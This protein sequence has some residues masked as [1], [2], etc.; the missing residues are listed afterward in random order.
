MVG[1]RSPWYD[2][3]E[4]FLPEVS[5]PPLRIGP[6]TSASEP[7]YHTDW[8]TAG[9]SYHGEQQPQQQARDDH[10]FPWQSTVGGPTHSSALASIASSVRPTPASPPTIREGGQVRTELEYAA[11]AT[12]ARPSHL[13]S[14]M[15]VSYHPPEAPVS[16]EVETPVTVAPALPP[17]PAAAWRG[18]PAPRLQREPTPP[19]DSV[20]LGD[21]FMSAADLAAVAA[22][23]GEVW[24]TF[25]GVDGSGQDTAG[26]ASFAGSG[27]GTGIGPAASSTASRAG[28][29][30]LSRATASTTSSSGGGGG[31][32][33][34][35]APVTVA[36]KW[37]CTSCP[38]SNAPT[39]TWC[40]ACGTHKSGEGPVRIM[41]RDDAPPLTFSSSAAMPRSQAA[42]PVAPQLAGTNRPA[43]PAPPL[44]HHVAPAP[45]APAGTGRRALKAA[46][47]AAAAVAATDT[48]PSSDKGGG[49]DTE[50]DSESAAPVSVTAGGGGGG[51]G[52]A[53]YVPFVKPGGGGKGGAA[54]AA[55]HAV[56]AA[57]IAADLSKSALATYDCVAGGEN[58]QVRGVW[59]VG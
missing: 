10:P 21:D 26:A 32:G 18:G 45:P 14:T 49:A 24:E 19:P 25:P 23:S 1:Y 59:G 11:T 56:K 22:A 29:G 4:A 12:L 53:G 51:D 27:W 9:A 36:R 31:R 40:F 5:L 3:L 7:A 28:N 2:L 52:G 38:A 42:R 30:L 20:Y 33:G 58:Q 54:I 41:R 13:S 46:A 47:A 6:S 17:P 34:A 43:F 16:G 37:L 15:G 44:P 55:A 8:V 39:S 48:P 50:G 35:A 57:K